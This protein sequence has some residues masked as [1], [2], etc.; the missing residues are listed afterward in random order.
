[1]PRSDFSPHGVGYT[2]SDT[3]ITTSGGYDL[4]IEAN[5]IFK[6]KDSAVKNTVNGTR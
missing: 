5:R 2:E 1:M 3:P 6:V 4:D